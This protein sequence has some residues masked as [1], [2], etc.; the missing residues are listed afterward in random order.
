MLELFI[1]FERAQLSRESIKLHVKV[2]MEAFNYPRYLTEEQKTEASQ[3]FAASQVLRCH[4]AFA[5]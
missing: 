4:E 1:I 2:T 5:E 3:D